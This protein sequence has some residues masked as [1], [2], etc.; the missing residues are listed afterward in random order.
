[1]CNAPPLYA[2]GAVVA[3]ILGVGDIMASAPRDGRRTAGRYLPKPPLAGFR[4]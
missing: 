4:G 2:D 1:M 3:A